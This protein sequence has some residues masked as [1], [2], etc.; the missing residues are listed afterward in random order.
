M[1]QINQFLTSIFGSS[2]DAKHSVIKTSFIIT[3]IIVATGLL[4]ELLKYSLRL[5]HIIV[6][7]FKPINYEH[8]S[9]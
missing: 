7:I 4:K 3:L 5:F 1:E 9:S 2:S 8:V 6:S